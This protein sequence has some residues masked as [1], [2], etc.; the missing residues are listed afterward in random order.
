MYIPV[1][2][3]EAETAKQFMSFL[4]SE[5]VANLAKEKLGKEIPVSGTTVIAPGFAVKSSSKHGYLPEQVNND[6]L[7]PA[8]VIGLGWS[9][10]MYIIVLEK[11]MGLK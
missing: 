8:W 9:H 3:K 11:L 4:Y 6:T 5:T 10:A 7:K 1:E 2:A